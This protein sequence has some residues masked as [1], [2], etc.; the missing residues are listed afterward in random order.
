MYTAANAIANNRA[1]LVTVDLSI[2]STYPHETITSTVNSVSVPSPAS[3]TDED[4]DDWASDFQMPY[5]GTSRSGEDATYEVRIDAADA[6]Q[7]TQV[8]CAFEFGI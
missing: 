1:A 4:L 8:D 5:T 6:Y 7:D 3:M 2:D